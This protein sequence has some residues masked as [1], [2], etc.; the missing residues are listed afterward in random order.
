MASKPFLI[1]NNYSLQTTDG[2]PSGF[3][4]QNIGETTGVHYELNKYHEWRDPGRRNV[5]QY[6]TRSRKRTLRKMGQC[7][8][9]PY[10]SSVA[11]SAWY[12]FVRERARDYQWIWFHDVWTMKACLDLLKPGQKTI[13][14]SH[15]PELPSQEVGAVA[16]DWTVVAERDAFARADVYVFPNE[17]AAK[18]YDSLFRPSAKLEYVLSAC[19]EARPRYV[20]PLDPRYVYYLFIGRRIAIKGFDLVLDAFKAAYAIDN[21]LRLLVVGKGEPLEIPG[22]L[23]IGYSDQPANWFAVCDYL[24]S[25][26]RQ[27]YFDLSVMEALSLGT[28]LIITCTNGH[29]F[30]GEIETPGVIAL[31]NADVESLTNAILE[32]RKKRFPENPASPGNKALY[33]AHFS[34]NVYRNRI[35]NLM[36]KLLGSVHFTHSDQQPVET[37]GGWVKILGNPVLGRDL[38]TCFDISVLKV[39]DIYRMWFSWRP[40]KSIA[41]VE[42]KDGIQW[43]KPEIVISPNDKTDWENNLNRPVVV[44]IDDRFQMW[45]TGQARGRSWIGYAIS[46][47]GKSWERMSDKPILSAEEPWEKGAVMAPH[48]IYDDKVKLYRMWYSGGEQN[49]PNAIGYATSEDGLNWTRVGKTPVFEPDSNST[50][51][52]ENDRVAACQVLRHGDW[53][54]MFYIGF[55]DENHAQI[56]IAR[57]KDGITDW[58]RHRDN[59]IIRPGKYQWDH[60]AVYKPYVIWD[61]NQWLLW[62]NGRKGDVEQIG[63]ALHQGE[64]L[65]F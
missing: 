1:F 33:N 37:T 63:L 40:K 52:W 55:R 50:N 27:S 48:V 31:P 20:I 12:T 57:S 36:E 16:H 10:F 65:G 5:W 24:V 3:L 8:P 13:L 22:V 11:L 47:D 62:Y 9:V 58:Q 21:S 42:S 49:E 15:C 56:G 51:G 64:D 46:K 39:G 38:G 30:F 28:P 29:K 23:D 7:S 25:A 59:P 17:H 4:A 32:N 44:K 35:E 53:Y 60:D 43:S 14:Q 18:I 45:Y 34:S 26:N 6:L 19:Q 41:V 54:L 61:G 2:G